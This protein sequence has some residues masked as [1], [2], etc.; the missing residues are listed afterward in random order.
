MKVRL[1]LLVTARVSARLIPMY[2]LISLNLLRQNVT[3]RCHASRTGATRGEGE[4][5]ES[6]FWHTQTVSLAWSPYVSTLDN[7]LG[8]SQVFL[9]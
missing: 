4:E 3:Q 5:Q 8:I 7:L 9:E 1:K 6:C 2:I